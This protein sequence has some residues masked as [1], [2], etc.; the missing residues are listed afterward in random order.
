MK[1]FNKQV[2]AI[3]YCE[4]NG[5]NENGV[6][7]LHKFDGTRRFCVETY[8]KFTDIYLGYDID[9]CHYYEVIREKTP[10]KLYFDIDISKTSAG[11]TSGS[12][13]V[14]IFVG[15]VSRCLLVDYTKQ[16]GPDQVLRLDSTSAT[17]FSQH[18]IYPDII[19][20][21]SQECGNFVRRISD[22]ANSA[23]DGKT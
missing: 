3:K 14:D 11:E 7:V 22:A 17:K 4:E 8:E 9:L 16:V 13:L 2:D 12:L 10:V 5:S 23:I 20:E 15:Y 6:F 21:N 1:W 19:F 18:L